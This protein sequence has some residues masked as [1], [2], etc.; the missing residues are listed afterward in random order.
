MD[1]I[2]R[3][4]AADVIQLSGISFDY[5][6][7]PGGYVQPGS[8]A[9]SN[10]CASKQPDRFN[11]SLNVGDLGLPQGISFEALFIG[12]PAGTDPT[13]GLAL[14]DWTID[15]QV[16][17]YVQEAGLTIDRIFGQ[18][19][20]SI[21]P[22]D[23]QEGIT[24]DG[25]KAF[26]NVRLDTV[27]GTNQLEVDGR[28]HVSPGINPGFQFYMTDVVLSA[29]A[30]GKV[31]SLAVSIET[32]NNP[33]RT[34]T[35]EGHTVTFSADLTGVPSQVFPSIQWSQA[36]GQVVG[37]SDG[38]TFKVTM[39]SPPQPVGITV[40]A[41]AG[42]IVTSTSIVLNPL[43]AVWV[44]FME[45]HCRASHLMKKWVVRPR[46]DPSDPALGHVLNRQVREADALGKQVRAFAEQVRHMEK[47]FAEG[48]LSLPHV[49]E[50]H[51]K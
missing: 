27:G 18:F 12:Q 49:A 15:Q 13:T 11:M 30:G 45:H 9:V 14:V 1:G 7:D 2:E 51:K 19:T 16:G 3:L 34:A 29:L 17:Q 28:K 6:A 37:R 26:F 50:H 20:T 35:A 33:C 5:H 39:P 43:P 31:A 44:A 38:E 4:T 41:T 24:C 42:D 21:T 25:G 22:I 8:V 36:G 32:W 47:A 46:P 40:K 10:K 23:S 48:T